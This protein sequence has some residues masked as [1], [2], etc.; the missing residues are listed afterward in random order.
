[1]EDSI[2][3]RRTRIHQQHAFYHVMIRGNNRQEI[4]SDDEDCEIFIEILKR[5]R[6]N[7]DFKI[8]LFCLMNNHVHFV[9]EVHHIPLSKIMQSINSNYANKH[10][11]RFSRVGHLFQG[12]YKSKQINDDE[13]LLELCYYIHMNPVNAGMVKHLNDY[14]WSSHHAY[15]H[16]NS[17]DWVYTEH[18][19]QLLMEAVST[20]K[21][22]YLEFMTDRNEKYKTPRSCAIDENGELIFKNSVSEKSQTSTFLALEN[23]P[24]RKIAEVICDQVGIDIKLLDSESQAHDVSLA[25]SMTAYFAHYHAK[26][27]L[28]DIAAVFCREPDSV[29]KA[30]HRCLRRAKNDKSIHHL[31]SILETKLS[32]LNTDILSLRLIEK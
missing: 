2:V 26:H 27:S 4:F 1:M 15:I 23:M 7:F 28:K 19:N 18:I 20:K 6:Q 8:H 16:S 11:H 9:F 24:L 12:R 17:S 30:L 22:H 21:H 32:V 31:I 29:S 25:R 5:V 13:Y 3:P 14:P 10:N